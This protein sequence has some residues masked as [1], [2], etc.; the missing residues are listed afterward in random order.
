MYYNIFVSTN[1][2]AYVIWKSNTS[3][4]SS[5]FY[6]KNNYRYKFFSVA[7]DSIGLAEAQK[8]NFEAN[9]LVKVPKIGVEE[10]TFEKPQFVVY[11]NPAG[12]G[13]MIHLLSPVDLTVEVSLIDIRGKELLHFTKMKLTS[14]ENA[15]NLQGLTLKQGVYFIVIDGQGKKLVIE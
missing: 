15:L 3:L 1:D 9:T 4:T 7:S 5:R 11:P 6:G 13:T 8:L 10:A 2:S 12:T 14:G